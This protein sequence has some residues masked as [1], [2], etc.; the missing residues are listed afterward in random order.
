MAYICNK[1]GGRMD[2]KDDHSTTAGCIAAYPITV[3]E[4]IWIDES[5]RRL[6]RYPEAIRL[7]K[8]WIKPGQY[9]YP[10]TETKAFLATE[11][12][13]RGEGGAG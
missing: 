2:Y 8:K 5:T 3:G 10:V 4:P 13:E 11:P 7:L 1:C 9:P 6:A 12:A